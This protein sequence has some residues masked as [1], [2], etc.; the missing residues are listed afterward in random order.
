MRPHFSSIKGYLREAL[1]GRN[2]PMLGAN[3]PNGEVPQEIA[4]GRLVVVCAART[5]D[6]AMKA[7]PLP[8]ALVERLQEAPAA[9]LA[10]KRAALEP[11]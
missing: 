8:Q 7:V 4:R 1:K 11:T 6:G 2:E 5:P 10:G 9:L 3:A